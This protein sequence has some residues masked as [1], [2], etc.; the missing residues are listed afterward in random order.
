MYNP[1][2]RTR[3]STMQPPQSQLNQLHQSSSSKNPFHTVVIEAWL[4]PLSALTPSLIAH[5]LEL[6]GIQLPHSVTITIDRGHYDCTGSNY[7]LIGVRAKSP[8]AFNLHH[9]PITQK[10]SFYCSFFSQKVT[11]GTT[12]PAA[13]N[14]HWL[15]NCCVFLG[16]DFE[17]HAS[18]YASQ[19]RHE[20]GHVKT[21]RKID[22]EADKAEAD[23]AEA[24]KAEADKAEA[25]LS[26]DA[27]SVGPTNPSP[28]RA[29]ANANAKIKFNALNAKD[30][31][32]IIQ[33][34]KKNLAL[35]T[36]LDSLKAELGAVKADMCAVKADMCAKFGPST[37]LVQRLN[38]QEVW[39]KRAN[40]CM[41]DW[42]NRQVIERVWMLE[43]QHAQ[44][45]SEHLKQKEQQKH[46][47]LQQQLK[48][49]HALHESVC[50]EMLERLTHLE[51]NMNAINPIH[52]NGCNKCNENY[53]NHNNHNN[54]NPFDF[55]AI[56]DHY[57]KTHYLDGGPDECPALDLIAN[58]HASVA[59]ESAVA[60]TSASVSASA[61]AADNDQ[62]DDDDMF[63]L[64][65]I[66]PSFN[67]PSAVLG[68]GALSK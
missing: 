40:Q 42:T 31:L 5:N 1:N 4:H 39:I 14:P 53:N 34:Q 58:H 49:Q 65:Q 55:S 17:T 36:E 26:E 12:D 18:Q 37:N 60:S 64:I 30:N 68:A 15:G 46:L 11:P 62:D 24:D 29:N 2:T 50:A 19:Y 38:E 22:P 47:D 52:S 28:K 23:K 3:S 44:L 43:T 21:W 45:R 8:V 61:A 63:E 59:V 51:S 33:L 48:K 32:R 54:P 20:P 56:Y 13:L 9:N 67:F 6:Q 35:R 57:D 41:Q 25:D 27:V 10:N 16:A 7:A 66:D